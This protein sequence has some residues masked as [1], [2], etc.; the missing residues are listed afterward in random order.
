M[1]ASAA[2]F[3]FRILAKWYGGK[4]YPILRST[5]DQVDFHVHV[6][7]PRLRVSA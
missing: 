3:I 5:E 6:S 4:A 2:G 7:T 1:T